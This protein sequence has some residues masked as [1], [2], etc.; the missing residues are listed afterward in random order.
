M[1]RCPTCNQTFSDEWLTFC[2]SDGTSLVAMDAYQAPTII[3]PPGDLPATI[4]EPAN[5]PAAYTPPT[6][7][8]PW[9][10]PPPAATFRGPSQTVAIWSLVLGLVSITLGWC[11]SFGLLT[12]PTA[13]ALG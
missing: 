2:T 6:G 7:P 4:N 8:S 10:P 1:K 3:A 12:A 5:F 9:Q 13:I 11:C